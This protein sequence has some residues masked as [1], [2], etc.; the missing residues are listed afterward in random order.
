[1]CTGDLAIS[2]TRQAY[3]ENV[4][5]AAGTDMNMP[6]QEPFPALHKE[7]EILQDEVGMSASDVIRAATATAARALN[8][9]EEMGTIAPGKLANL[10][11]VSKNPLE[12]VSNL[13]SVEF[14]VKRGVLYR[15][16]DY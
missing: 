8:Q 4:P 11:F 16:A 13:R 7:L 15:R 14:T 2:L 1:G 10:V 5:I 3:R 9:H 6:W 12:D